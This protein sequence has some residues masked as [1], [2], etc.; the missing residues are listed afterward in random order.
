MKLFSL[1]IVLI[2]L[3]AA[4]QLYA[5]TI[6][7]PLSDFKSIKLY[8][9]AKVN[10]KQGPKQIINITGDKA[11]IDQ[12]NQEVANGVWDVKFNN[13]PPAKYSGLVIDITVTD[14]E[15]VSV[16]GPG[17]ITGQEKITATGRLALQVYGSGNIQLVANASELESSI[18]GS[19]NIKVEGSA[20][21]HEV[22]ISGSGNVEAYGFQAP[23]VSV[24]TAGSGNAEVYATTHL[25]VSISGSGNVTY[26]GQPTIDVDIKGSGKLAAE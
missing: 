8:L 18:K 9:N 17:S 16:Y 19:G 12:I 24:N 2:G 13:T 23:K 3:F 26:R 5:E 22:R 7:L 20:K 25:S 1:W 15:A 21:V 6:E 4:N 10:L 14:L 11:I